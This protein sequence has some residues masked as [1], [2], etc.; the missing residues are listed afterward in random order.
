MYSYPSYISIGAESLSSLDTTWSQ[1]SNFDGIREKEP[2]AKAPAKGN[3]G[4]PKKKQPVDTGK[5]PGAKSK[6]VTTN[7]KDFANGKNK[8]KASD[9]VVNKLVK[10]AKIKK[11][12]SKKASLKAEAAAAAA[13]AAAEVRRRST[14]SMRLRK[15]TSAGEVCHDDS[16]ESMSE[17]EKLA[18]AIRRSKL[19]TSMTK[20]NSFVVHGKKVNGKKGKG[21]N[22]TFV[23]QHKM[24]NRLA[25]Q[26]G[27]KQKTKIAPGKVD[28]SKRK[29]HTAPDDLK[30]SVFSDKKDHYIG[31]DKEHFIGHF[32]A[33]T[34][35]VKKGS[36]TKN[37]IPSMVVTSRSAT[38]GRKN[39][40]ISR[41]NKAHMVL[42]RSNSAPS[43][44]ATLA[45]KIIPIQAPMIWK[46]VNSNQQKKTDTVEI[47][48]IQNM[49]NNATLKFTGEQKVLITF[50]PTSDSQNATTVKTI[51]ANVPTTSKTSPKSSTGVKTR[52]AVLLPITTE[53]TQSN[54]SNSTPTVSKQPTR[55]LRSATKAATSSPNYSIIP[56]S[57]L[58][59][60]SSAVSALPSLLSA[61]HKNAKISAATATA[62]STQKV[63]ASSKTLTNIAAPSQGKQ[64]QNMSPVKLIVVS[65]I[66]TSLSNMT[67]ASIPVAQNGSLPITT[68]LSTAASSAVSTTIAPVV[69]KQ[70]FIP[71]NS[72]TL[73]IKHTGSSQQVFTL[74]PTMGQKPGGPVQLIQGPVTQVA[75][76]PAV[77]STV[78]SSSVMRP[79]FIAAQPTPPKQ[80]AT[81]PV[82]AT[83][84]P[85]PQAVFIAGGPVNKT[86]NTPGNALQLTLQQNKSL[87]AGAVPL[88][89]SPQTSGSLSSQI[90]MALSSLQAQNIVISATTPN[91]IVNNANGIQTNPS[92]N[93]TS[94]IQQVSNSKQITTQPIAITKATLRERPTIL[95]RAASTTVV[96]AAMRKINFA[97]ETTTTTSSGLVVKSQSLAAS[98]PSNA[99]MVGQ[100]AVANGADKGV[101]DGSFAAATSSDSSAA[102]GLSPGKE[103]LEYLPTL[104]GASL[105]S[106]SKLPKADP[107]VVKIPLEKLVRNK[108][109]DYEKNESL[110]SASKGVSLAQ[111]DL[112]DITQIIKQA[113]NLELP[114]NS[115]GATFVVLSP[116]KNKQSDVS[117]IGGS[118]PGT[119]LTPRSALSLAGEVT[120]PSTNTLL[121]SKA[122]GQRPTMANLSLPNSVV[123]SVVP[124]ASLT[125][126]PALK[127]PIVT[128]L[129]IN[130]PAI[131]HTIPTPAVVTSPSLSKNPERLPLSIKLASIAS[132]TRLRNSRPLKTAPKTSVAVVSG[133]QI[134]IPAQQTPLLPRPTQGF[135]TLLAP[136][137]ITTLANSLQTVPQPGNGALQRFPLTYLTT[138]PLQLGNGSRAQVMVQQSAPR[139]VFPTGIASGTQPAASNNVRLG[140]QTM[141]IPVTLSIPGI[142]LQ[143]GTA[144]SNTLFSTFYSMVSA[145]KPKQTIAAAPQQAIAK[146][147]TTWGANLVQS[148]ASVAT[149]SKLQKIAPQPTRSGVCQNSTDLI[150]APLGTMRV[151]NGNKAIE[152]I[153]T[154]PV[155]TG[156]QPSSTKTSESSNEFQG[157]STASA[158]LKASG[159]RGQVADPTTTSI[160]ST[161]SS[162]TVTLAAT[163]TTTTATTTATTDPSTTASPSRDGILDLTNSLQSLLKTDIKQ[164][165]TITINIQGSPVTYAL[166]DGKLFAMPHDKLSKEEKSAATGA[167]DSTVEETKDQETTKAELKT[168][169][170]TTTQVESKQ[171]DLVPPCDQTMSDVQGP[172][173]VQ[174]AAK[175]PVTINPEITSKAQT[176]ADCPTVLPTR[177]SSDCP[178]TSPAQTASEMQPDFRDKEP[179]LSQAGGVI[180]TADGN[181]THSTLSVTTSLPQDLVSTRSITRSTSAECTSSQKAASNVIERRKSDFPA[182]RPMLRVSVPTALLKRKIRRSTNN[183]SMNVTTNDP[184]N[185]TTNV[186]T[187]HQLRNVTEKPP[188]SQRTPSF[189]ISVSVSDTPSL[190][191]LQSLKKLPRDIVSSDVVCSTTSIVVVKDSRN[192]MD[193]ID[194]KMKLLKE[195]ERRRK[196]CENNELRT[197]MS[198]NNGTKVSDSDENDLKFGFEC[199]F[200]SEKFGSYNLMWRHRKLHLNDTTTF[201]STRRTSLPRAICPK[202]A[203]CETCQKCFQS[204][205]DLENHLQ[206]GDC[207]NVINTPV[208]NDDVL[209]NFRVPSPSV[210]GGGNIDFLETIT[211]VSSLATVHSN[212]AITAHSKGARLVTSNH[213]TDNAMDFVT[214]GNEVMRTA[215][216]GVLDSE[217]FSNS[218]NENDTNLSELLNGLTETLIGQT[219]PP[220]GVNSG[221]MG[222]V[223]EDFDLNANFDDQV[224]EENIQQDIKPD[225][226]PPK[227]F[228]RSS[229][230]SSTPRKRINSSK[231]SI[232]KYSISSKGSANQKRG[233][234]RSRITISD[235]EDAAQDAGLDL[236]GEFITVGKLHG[237]YTCSRCDQGFQNEEELDEHNETFHDS[238]RYNFRERRSVS[239]LDYLDEFEFD[240]E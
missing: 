31:A 65:S 51:I 183:D 56:L 84:N 165:S 137:P 23:F 150:S 33:G 171:L 118:L 10:N 208:T 106:P 212:E 99:S 173:E 88:I 141:M 13:A 222:N 30:K 167:K 35:K 1:D 193:V 215:N 195:N 175:A 26:Q 119:I 177:S 90:Q 100:E 101:A 187:S 194:S 109:S 58:I 38:N 32:K 61:V 64:L 11:K 140:T 117:G 67:S 227:R 135:L 25:G 116:E 12:E 197:H 78:S 74:I 206:Q 154:V 188:V 4:T 123:S 114:S 142:N 87:F 47:Q 53:T 125:N 9:D 77:S 81:A 50:N 91:Q 136:K 15:L 152:N 138:L 216:L 233:K 181:S 29:H 207:N 162:A 37:M 180:S 199:D 232:R 134:P 121:T 68:T 48:G 122:L 104:P 133:K 40:A 218:S 20:N 229:S 18:E 73:I 107:L 204:N 160:S 219:A 80:P 210:N 157:A 170:E 176:V 28:Q 129:V 161:L 17:S 213:I 223:M 156:A 200:C 22:V 239:N 178:R 24:K 146:T 126:T 62:V 102:N 21:D 230:K 231:S 139:A 203:V 153:S 79:I 103:I 235:E 205:A 164:G 14:N 49:K 2:R 66:P 124:T 108:K 201:S 198:E 159:I 85:Q 96:N 226:K 151:I 221:M 113:T 190:S 191:T 130:T 220:V 112:A 196:S 41:E 42:K 43:K 76:K 34:K 127:T 8:R 115:S 202:I 144:T 158:T 39:S 184:T 98:G 95:R 44:P 240:F 186:T 72:K 145:A 143:Q 128:P 238:L 120:Q 93:A 131:R 174:G 209:R 83:S 27:T 97:Q 166:R 228:R 182:A 172:A 110:A 192:E 89:F 16:S 214:S 155:K 236:D 147:T 148:K 225:V 45:G 36:R 94:A 57:S 82:A 92:V 86:N 52:Q 60:S 3:K 69:A 169:G 234:R 217:A 237:E 75:Q 211:S 71:Q 224:F 59:A 54:T 149:A 163:T 7:K 179:A 189:P 19:E 55:A 111:N 105:T 70:A 5:S 168:Q 185:I 46:L 6:A 63:I 132:G